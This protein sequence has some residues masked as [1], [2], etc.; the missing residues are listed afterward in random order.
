MDGVETVERI[1]KNHPDLPVYA[2]TAN[3]AAG[4]EFYK[5]RGFDGYLS[6]PID[7]RTL[8]RTI[9]QHLPDEMM[10]KPVAEDVVEELTEIPGNL[11]WIYDTEGITVEEGIK[12]SGGISNYIFSL[13][14]FLDTL[15]SN[16]KVIRDSY[17]S[18]NI[19]LFTIKVHSLKSSARI[20]GAME[21]SKL[22]EALEDAGNKEDMSYIDANTNRLLAEYEAFREKLSGLHDNEDDSDKEMISEDELREAYR[23][24]ADVIPQMDYDAVEMIIEQLNEYA[25]PE[26]V[27]AKIKELSKML[28]LFD[29]DGME[30]LITA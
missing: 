27:A 6:K 21:L 26:D 12:N 14:L 5:S 17:E 22:A 30:A 29:W 4:E 1:R 3:T 28:K 8:E 13:N 19:R 10:D 11:K 25:L 2:L 23:A 24:L 16:A 9:M 18:G 15:D 20:I 7:S